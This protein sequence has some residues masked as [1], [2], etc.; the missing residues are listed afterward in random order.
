MV[1]NVIGLMTRTYKLK[2]GTVMTAQ[3]VRGENWNVSVADNHGR[4]VTDKIF[5]LGVEVIEAV[6]HDRL[7]YLLVESRK[8]DSKSK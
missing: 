8:W 4:N 3:S 7:D 2:N 5:H 1:D 6:S